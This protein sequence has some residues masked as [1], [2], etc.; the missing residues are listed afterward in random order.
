MSSSCTINNEEESV[1]L[2]QNKK[3]NEN[4]KKIDDINY[5]YMD[6]TKK[7]INREPNFIKQN[8]VKYFIFYYKI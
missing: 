6:L 1:V 3:N 4:Y 2:Y 7:K 8:I 5:L